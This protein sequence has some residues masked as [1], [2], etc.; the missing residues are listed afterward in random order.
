VISKKDIDE[1]SLWVDSG[2]PLAYHGGGQR[3]H[4]LLST[5]PAV[6]VGSNPGSLTTD[7]RGNGFAREVPT[8]LPDIGAYERQVNDDEVFYAGF[9][10]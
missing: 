2:P 9:D 3:T 6:D 1:R 8:G 4:A 10:P 5:S 7:Q